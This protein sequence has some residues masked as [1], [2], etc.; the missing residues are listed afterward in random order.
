MNFGPL[1]V[2]LLETPR[3]GLHDPRILWAKVQ[4]RWSYG[5]GGQKTENPHFLE[6]DE[7]WSTYCETSG[8]P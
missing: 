3:A 4:K 2:T 7:L 1:M 6:T 5:D 8:K